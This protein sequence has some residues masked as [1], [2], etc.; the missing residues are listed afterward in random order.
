MSELA[1]SV[2]S[3]TACLCQPDVWKA[4][5]GQRLA[6]VAVAAIHSPTAAA[7]GQT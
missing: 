4:T 6:L 2:H 7:G 1:L 3:Q 5:K